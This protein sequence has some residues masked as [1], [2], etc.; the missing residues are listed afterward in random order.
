MHTAVSNPGTDSLMPHKTPPI[1]TVAR[2]G[3][4]PENQTKKF[5]IFA[6]FLLKNLKETFEHRPK[7]PV[8]IN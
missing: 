5:I 7:I 8:A 6:C 2:G 3:K 4:R 1:S